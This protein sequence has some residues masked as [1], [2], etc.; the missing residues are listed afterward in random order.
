MISECH[1]I[2]SDEASVMSLVS[3]TEESAIACDAAVAM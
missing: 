2:C 1:K 3:E